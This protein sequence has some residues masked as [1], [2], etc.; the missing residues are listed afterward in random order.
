MQKVEQVAFLDLKAQFSDMEREILAGVQEVCQS[1][2]FVLGSAVG[3]FEQSF[4]DYI[5][6]YKSEPELSMEQALEQRIQSLSN[7]THPNRCVGVGNGTDALEIAIAA[8]DL[9]PKSEIIVPANAYFACVEAVLNA[10]MRA[11][12]VDCE[13]D[14]S[15][16]PKDSMLTPQTRAILCVHLYGAMQHISAFEAYAQKHSLKLIEDC[17]QAHGASDEKG[18]RA[19]SIG[20]IACFSFYPGKNLGCYGDGG[21]V[22][23]KDLALVQKARELA[24]HG[25]KFANGIWEKNTHLSLGRNSRLDSIQAK[26]LH[27]KLASLDRHNAHRQRCA[28]EYCTQLERFSYL[29][30]PSVFAQSVWH[31]FV[32]ECCGRAESKRDELLDFLRQRG[33]ECGVHYPNALSE[34]AILQACDDVAIHNAPNAKHRASTIL[35]LPIGEHLDFSHIAYIAQVLAEF[36]QTL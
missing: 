10:G 28:R 12:V 8:L 36:E 20:D 2:E 32:L 33:V 9:P 18:R 16:T 15:F 4:S 24:N 5:F 17:A 13:E 35:S 21:A 23:S 11:V 29:K 1:A 14:G 34:I 31:L 22:V 7:S 30:L 27:L 3:E 19:G 6:S 26:I 25:Q